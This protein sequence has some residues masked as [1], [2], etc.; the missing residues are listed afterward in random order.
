[1]ICV[2]AGSG[3]QQPIQEIINGE[4]IW[5]DKIKMNGFSLFLP[6]SSDAVDKA[7]V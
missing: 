7:D 5:S 2:S 3:H 1:M 4:E 6:E